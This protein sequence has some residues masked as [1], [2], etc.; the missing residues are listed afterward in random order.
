MPLSNSEELRRQISCL[1]SVK[2][3]NRSLTKDEFEDLWHTIC[4][5]EKINDQRSIGVCLEV[6]MQQ[7]NMRTSGKSDNKVPVDEEILSKI[8]TRCASETTPSMATNRGMA[9]EILNTYSR[10][11]RQAD[12]G[13]QMQSLQSS[14]NSQAVESVGG[15][16]GLQALIPK[17]EKSTSTRMCL[18]QLSESND[19]NR[20]TLL[21]KT[22]ST[23]SRD[24]M[25]QMRKKYNLSHK[26]IQI[27]KK[28]CNAEYGFEQ[29]ASKNGTFQYY[30]A[31]L[32]LLLASDYAV[33]LEFLQ[34]KT[35][36]WLSQLIEEALIYAND[37]ALQGEERQKAD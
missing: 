27:L 26:L 37:Q 17:M 8:I 2:E 36:E 19:I 11:E 13:V 30:L 29:L 10:I 4:F 12:Q 33:F 1:L 24:S 9:H 22:L 3:E 5:A 20:V 7:L 25:I 15:G 35:L 18:F 31:K 32:M 6:I 28:Y 16:S 23:K 34:T 21:L 14:L